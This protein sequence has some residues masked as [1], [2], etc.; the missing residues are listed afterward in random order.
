MV[1]LPGVHKPKRCKEHDVQREVLLAVLPVNTKQAH[2]KHHYNTY[3]IGRQERAF[4]IGTVYKHLTKGRCPCCDM[5]RAG[6]DVSVLDVGCG[7]NLIYPLLGAALH[8][9]RFV[10]S[11]VTDVALEGAER[12]AAANPHLAHLIKLRRVEANSP[13]GAAGDAD[14][15]SCGPA[16]NRRKAAVDNEVI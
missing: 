12:N 16:L 3:C 4:A 9:W 15:I 10:G 13:L 7:A 5:E 2:A 14:I 1:I 8:R 6:D 11:D